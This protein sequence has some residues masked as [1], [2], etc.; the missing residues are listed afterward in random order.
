M[1]LFAG[2][3]KWTLGSLGL[4]NEVPKVP[5]VLQVPLTRPPLSEKATQPAFSMILELLSWLHESPLLRGPYY[6]AW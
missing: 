2:S 6:R 1:D 3:K 5:K 4:P